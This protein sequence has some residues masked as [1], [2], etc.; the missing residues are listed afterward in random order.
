MTFVDRP[1]RVASSLFG[2]T[3]A[4]DR[5]HSAA[6]QRPDA[7]QALFL[8][9]PSGVPDLCCGLSGPGNWG[10][11]PRTSSTPTESRMPPRPRFRGRHPRMDL[12][13]GRKTRELPR[14]Q[15]GALLERRLQ[16]LQGTSRR[17]RG[18]HE[19][20]VVIE[21][22]LAP[23]VEERCPEVASHPFEAMSVAATPHELAHQTPSDPQFPRPGP[24][25]IE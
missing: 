15:E 21:Q 23:Q 1:F 24:Q 17:W 14:G 10:R 12:A 6:D 4:R 25:E 13:S 20:I 22:A 19:C 3:G 11:S 16:L 5:K 9:L 7:W 18:R 2:S 8:I